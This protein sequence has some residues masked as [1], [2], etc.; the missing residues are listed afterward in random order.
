MSDSRLPEQL[1]DALESHPKASALSAVV[2]TVCIHAAEER[3]VRLGDGLGE[4]LR[5]AGLELDD[6]ETGS[7]NALR[8]LDTDPMAAD[9][10]Q[11][12][13]ALLARS[14]AKETAAEAELP[15]LAGQ[16]A[17]LAAYVGVDALAWLDRALGDAATPLWRALAVQLPALDRPS[18]VLAA[19]ALGASTLPAAQEAARK[20]AREL[21]DPA[22]Q[23]LLVVAHPAATSDAPAPEEARV[24]CEL[25]SPPMRP[26]VLVLTAI[27][28]IL[29]LRYLLRL[30]S[31]LLRMRR[32]AELLVTSA[33]VAVTS[34]WEV[35]GRRVRSRTVHIPVHNLAQA[36]RDV[37]YPRLAM[38]AGLV[39]LAA[40]SYVGFSLVTDGVRASSPSLL[41]LGAGIFGAGL[42]VDFAFSS[43]F[44]GR[45]GKYGLLIVPRKGRRIALRTRD[46]LSADAALAALARA[47]R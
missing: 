47:V 42:L 45:R 23:R 20:L 41:A 35:L 39:A 34:E 27:T 43:L 5:E 4:I 44:P 19:S 13:S 28:G 6:G 16:L 17:W 3:R 2:R 30:L 29:L 21:A 33:T 9:D 40:G 26:V 25:S 36:S 15:A 32:P 37:R 8:A 46:A 18:A 14:L 7:G 10:Q 22:L 24:K 31:L 1:I 12:L 38:Y 11:L